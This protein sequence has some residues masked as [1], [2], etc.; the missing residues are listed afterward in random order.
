MERS[1]WPLIGA[2][3]VTQLA[4]EE[5]CL[6]CFLWDSPSLDIIEVFLSRSSDIDPPAT[7]SIPRGISYSLE[8]VTAES[9]TEEA[10][11]FAPSLLPFVGSSSSSSR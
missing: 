11:V 5:F 7:I 10:P 4:N 2:G 6:Q 1:L 9:L 8:E 3:A